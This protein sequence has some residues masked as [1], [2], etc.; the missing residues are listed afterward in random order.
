MHLDLVNA[1]FY[2]SIGVQNVSDLSVG[3][4]CQVATQKYKK[5]NNNNKIYTKII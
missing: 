3:V 5:E 2:M 1:T 4:Y